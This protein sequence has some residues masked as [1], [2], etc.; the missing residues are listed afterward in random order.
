MIRYCMLV[1]LVA[2]SFSATAQTY[3][4]VQG[5]KAVFSDIPCASGANRVDQH[6][7][8]VSRDQRR[9]AELVNQKNNTQ[10]YELESNAAQGRHQRNSVQV[11]QGDATP[12]EQINNRGYRNR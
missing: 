8:G 7:D 1:L 11:L 2:G 4:C 3:K 6:T 9:Q 10:L 12:S 5:G